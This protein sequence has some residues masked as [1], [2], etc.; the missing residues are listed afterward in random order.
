MILVSACLVGEKCR[1]DGGSF[2]YKWIKDLVENNLAIPICPEIEGGLSTPRTPSEIRIINGEKKV[3]DKLGADLTEHFIKGAE[4]TL[5]TALSTGASCAILKSLSPSCGK[6]KIYSG[7]FD[8]KLVE[9][10][11][12]TCDILMKNKIKI[13]DENEK[14]LFEEFYKS[15]KAKS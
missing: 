7:N 13:F 12:L 11:G 2:E 8:K 15:L 1:Y 4:E 9:G 10:N 6:G 5:E 3:I 14:K